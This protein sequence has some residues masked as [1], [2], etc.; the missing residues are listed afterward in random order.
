MPFTL[1][2]FLKKVVLHVLGLSSLLFLN[3][4]EFG[5]FVVLPNAHLF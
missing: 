1:I 3:R 5:V 2:L 4:A